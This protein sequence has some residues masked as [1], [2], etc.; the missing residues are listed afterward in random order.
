MES[1]QSSTENRWEYSRHFLG[2]PTY[3]FAHAKVKKSNFSSKILEFVGDIGVIYN[4]CSSWL[5]P[6]SQ[7]KIGMKFLWAENPKIYGIQPIF[8]FVFDYAK[9]E[10]R[11]FESNS[12]TF[13]SQEIGSS[14]VS[15]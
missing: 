10:N 15:F 11:V 8:D 6:T 9:R 12:L 7:L 4:D 14:S 1:F 5:F 13:S 3:G 2:L